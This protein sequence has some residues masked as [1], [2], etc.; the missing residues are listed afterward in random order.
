VGSF[1]E[2]GS[3]GEAPKTK[4]PASQLLRETALL[5]QGRAA[6]RAG[7]IGLTWKI[8][9]QWGAEFPVAQLN[10]EREAL[11]IELLWQS[12]RKDLAQQ[13]IRAFE[14]DYPSSAHAARLKA[15]LAP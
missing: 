8:L 6:L 4:A 9:E 15:L 13:R 7:N 11:A 3:T 2:P 12:G 10:Q 14:R 5:E 1:A